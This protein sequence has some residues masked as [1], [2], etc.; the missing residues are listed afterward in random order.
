MILEYHGQYAVLLEFNPATGRLRSYRCDDLAERNGVQ[1]RG[2]YGL[3]GDTVVILYRSDAGRLT[4]RVGERE[5]SMN[6]GLEITRGCL[7]GVN[8]LLVV[9][10]GKPWAVLTYEPPLVDPPFDASGAPDDEEEFFDF[11]LFLA[12]VSTDAARQARLYGGGGPG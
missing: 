12:N 3:L 1:V 6:S 2:I 7:P 11:G 8:R 5:C 10:G 4:L 9:R